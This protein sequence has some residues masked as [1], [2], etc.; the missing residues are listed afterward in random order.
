MTNAPT[1][2]ALPAGRKRGWYDD[3][4]GNKGVD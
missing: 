1:L 4:N 3:I 2:P